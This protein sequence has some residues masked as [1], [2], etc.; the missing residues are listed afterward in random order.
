MASTASSPSQFHALLSSNPCEFLQR[1]SCISSTPVR[2]RKTLRVLAMAP[3]KKVNKYDENWKKQWYGAGLFAEGSEELQVDVVKKLEKKKVLSN[4]E[5]LGFLSKAEELGFTLSSIE[6]LGFLSKA[7]EL[8]LLSLVEQA[9][10]FSPSALAASALP[11]SVAAVAAVVVIPDDSIALVA[12]QAV[13]AG[14]LGVAAAGAF[15]G[16]VVL[17]G[18]QESD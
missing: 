1:K 12:A 4:V 6:K 3:N 10:G 16:S 15:L 8:G 14:A 9:A 11:L 18:L 17:G 5:K 2:Y 7:E 13:L